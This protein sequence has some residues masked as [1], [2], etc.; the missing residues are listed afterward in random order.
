M[1]CLPAPI[2]ADSGLSRP[3]TA[4]GLRGWLLVYMAGLVVQG[5]HG[6]GLTVAAV[7][8]YADPARA[9]LTSFVSL[10]ALLF[11]VVT[12]VAVAIYTAVVLVLMVRRRKA[13]IV[14][15]VVLN[16]LTVAILISWHFLGEKSPVGTVVDSLPSVVGIA[17]ML[18]SKRVSAT[19]IRHGEA[20][21]SPLEAPAP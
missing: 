14:N 1:N 5:L 19:F 15:A 9:G 11:Y 3:G 18:W 7:V 13:A 12:N 20:T 17:Y 2:D 21:R 16:C 8:I 10:R 4:A 6:L